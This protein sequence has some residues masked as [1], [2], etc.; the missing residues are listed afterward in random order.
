VRADYLAEGLRIPLPE[1]AHEL[2]LDTRSIA[3]PSAP[4]VE[5]ALALDGEAALRVEHDA[6]E[7]PDGPF[8]VEAWVW[9][10]EFRKRQ[11]FL[12]MTEQC[13]F[14]VFL[15][16]GAP[17]FTVHLGGRYVAAKSETPVLRAKTWHHVAGVFD[18][19]EVRLFVDGRQLAAQPGRGARTRKPLPLIVGGDVGAD[20]SA[21]SQLR[22]FVDEVRISRGARYTSGAAFAPSRRCESDA[23]TALLLH[24]DS[25]AGPWSLDASPRRAHATRLGDAHSATAP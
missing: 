7:L 10:D 1:K 14:G 8:T 12:N 3:L 6:L 18:G 15:D 24:M 25:D 2:P 19:A 23:D 17:S 9:A 16:N 20:G 13:E 22:G 5:R 11:G 21:N 4:A